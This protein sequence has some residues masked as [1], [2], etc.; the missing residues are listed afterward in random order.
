MN[1]GKKRIWTIL[2]TAVL[3][4]ALC[5]PV[6]AT[7]EGFGD[8]ALTGDQSPLVPVVLLLAL[9]AVGLVVVVI[10]I[11]RSGGK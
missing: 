1:S 8:N 6:A 5:L 7:A 4:I 10:I 3:L 11:R 2:L 9:S